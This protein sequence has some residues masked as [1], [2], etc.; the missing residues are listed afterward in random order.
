MITKRH[1]PT[2]F[3]TVSETLSP[4][5]INESLYNKNTFPSIYTILYHTLMILSSLISSLLD[6][7]PKVWYNMVWSIFGD[8]YDL[9]YRRTA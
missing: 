5:D 3:A 6:I 4:R 8:N 1:D 9:C 7:Y 2:T